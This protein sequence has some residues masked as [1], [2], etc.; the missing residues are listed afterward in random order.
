MTR[1]G[2][3]FLSSSVGSNDGKNHEI[4][5]VDPNGT[6]VDHQVLLK[7]HEYEGSNVA[8]QT[9]HQDLQI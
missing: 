2:T 9:R 3:S 6:G 1:Y 5:L 7:V 8:E 4:K